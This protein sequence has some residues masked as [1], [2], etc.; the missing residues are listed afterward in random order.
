MLV[1]APLVERGL[2]CPTRATG[3]RV[4]ASGNG[5]VRKCIS[6][7]IFRS[8]AERFT[9]GSIARKR[10]QVIHFQTY[11]DFFANS[12]IVMSFVPS[13]HN[14]AI[15]EKIGIRLE[16]DHLVVFTRG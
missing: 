7:V 1:S 15:G 13:H 11:A 16:M 6:V 5:S 12:M 10:H 4:P 2:L 9:R 8:R 14:H 3:Y